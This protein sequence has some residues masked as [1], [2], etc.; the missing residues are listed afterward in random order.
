MPGAQV[1]DWLGEPLPLDVA[2]TVRR[3]GGSYQE[4]WSTGADVA[5]WAEHQAGRLP[6]LTAKDADADLATLRQVRD[7]VFAVL[8]AVATHQSCAADV[9]D[10]I[11]TRARTHPVVP[12]LTARIGVTTAVL[13]LEI[14][15]VEALLA[16]V[17][18]ATITFTISA[19]AGHLALCDAPS[20]GQF[21]LR[22]RT[23]QHWCSAACGTRSRV[24]RHARLGRA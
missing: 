16:H 13:T 7:D 10:R 14:D 8:L 20:C 4:L 11:N 23:N 21:F 18:H 5:R 15:P 1:W 24:A 22:E 9:A 6:R 3:R 12:V 2:N 17:V 19:E